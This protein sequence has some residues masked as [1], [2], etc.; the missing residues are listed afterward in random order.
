MKRVTLFFCTIFLCGCCFAQSPDGSSISIGVGYGVDYGGL[1]GK[2]SIKPVEN[3]G[4]VGGIGNYFGP[5][6]SSGSIDNVG[7]LTGKNLKGFGFS[8]GI[9]YF[10]GSPHFGGGVHY[11]STGIY[12]GEE[13]LQGINWCMFG[14]DVYFNSVPLF[15]HYGVNLGFVFYH[16]HVGGM[17]GVSVGIGY[18]FDLSRSKKNVQTKHLRNL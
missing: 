7:R 11:I 10:Y 18:S 4:I 16:G 6:L 1:G 5:P 17:I 9:E 3:F 15:I 14:G 2:I 13:S 8:V 12:N